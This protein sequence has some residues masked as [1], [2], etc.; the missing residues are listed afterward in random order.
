MNTRRLVCALA[1]MNVV[2]LA[3]YAT[4]IAD[5][6]FP[7]SGPPVLRGRALEIVDEEGRVR[8]SISILPAGRSGAGEAHQETVLLRLMTERGRPTVKIGSSE[9][10]SGL[11][12]SGPT[13]TSDTY[14]ILEAKE[15]ATS[16]RMRNEGGRER[17]VTP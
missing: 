16:L 2:V 4:Q 14:V 7:D 11:S 10:T 1:L 13:G 12:F 6:A 9:Q 5:A 3:L 8:A 15:R 17:R